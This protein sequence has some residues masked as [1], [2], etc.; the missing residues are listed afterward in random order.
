MNHCIC[1]PGPPIPIPET[2]KHNRN[3]SQKVVANQIVSLNKRHTFQ[4]VFE[5]YFLARKVQQS[6]SHTEWL[7]K[8]SFLLYSFNSPNVISIRPMEIFSTI[9]G[10]LMI[11]M[12]NGHITY[13]RGPLVY[14]FIYIFFSSVST[15]LPINTGT[16]SHATYLFTKV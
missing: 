11:H 7:P 1:S 14:I 2:E 12:H 15:N 5:V 16:T 13:R 10:S 9:H 3:A 4:I 8:G 6:N